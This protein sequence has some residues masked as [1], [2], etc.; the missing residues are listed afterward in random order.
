MHSQSSFLPISHH[1]SFRSSRKIARWFRTQPPCK[2]SRFEPS[3]DRYRLTDNWPLFT[4][5]SSNSG[6]TPPKSGPPKRQQCRRRVGHFHSD[7]NATAARVFCNRNAR[8][9]GEGGMVMLSQKRSS[10]SR[11]P[12]DVQHGS[13]IGGTSGTVNEREH[14]DER[15][16]TFGGPA[17]LR[18]RGLS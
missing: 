3:I 15:T 5:E 7:D 10:V 16:T 13:E 6:W 11:W 12:P 14:F 18:T 1:K 8:Y 17:M 2:E 4:G 9:R